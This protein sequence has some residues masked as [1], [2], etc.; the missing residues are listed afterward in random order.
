MTADLRKM[1]PPEGVELVYERGQWRF[2]SAWSIGRLLNPEGPTYV[3]SDV[4]EAA[5]ARVR[6]E[7]LEDAAQECDRFAESDY[8][9]AIIGARIRALDPKGATK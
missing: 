6:S 1:V 3:R 5:L 9:G 8:R 2:K 4:H 7:A